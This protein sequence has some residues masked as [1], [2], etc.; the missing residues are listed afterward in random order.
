MCKTNKQTKKANGREQYAVII[1]MGRFQSDSFLA[2]I[3]VWIL[4]FLMKQINEPRRDKSETK[5]KI[6][7]VT[8]Q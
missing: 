4:V 1:A 7:I 8:T 2:L 5:T 3:V 6:D